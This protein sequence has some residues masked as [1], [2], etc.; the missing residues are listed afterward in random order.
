MD[1]QSVGHIFLVKHREWKDT[2]KL[3]LL[4]VEPCVRGMGVGEALVTECVRFARIAGYK[5]IVLWTQSTL[6]AAHKLY[7]RAGFRLVKEEPHHSF[8]IDLVGQEWELQ[9]HD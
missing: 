3:R 4:F 6:A 8:G 7:E 1:G 5:R 2:A 9:L